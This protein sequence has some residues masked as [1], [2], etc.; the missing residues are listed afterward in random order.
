[1]SS[2]PK[3]FL[4]VVLLSLAPSATAQTVGG[5]V[6]GT[7]TD[8]NHAVMPDVKVM[9]VNSATHEA[10]TVISDSEGLYAISALPPGAYVLTASAKGFE[11]FPQPLELQVNQNLRIDMTMEVATV[12]FTADG[13]VL[14]PA[15]LKKDSASLGTV[16]ENRQVAGLPLDGRNFYELGLL[17]PGAA[18]AAPGSAGS[19]RGDF[20][21]SVNGAR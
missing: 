3:T 9:L 10:R 18:P 7:I 11:R 1:M 16:I 19:V 20:S 8:Q 2:V 5:S 13:V 14:P 21:F 4:L 17:V 6:R 12:G 15:D